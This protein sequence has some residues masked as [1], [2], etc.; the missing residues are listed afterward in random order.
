MLQVKKVPTMMNHDPERKTSTKPL[1]IRPYCQR[2]LGE[3]GPKIG[4]GFHVHGVSWSYGALTVSHRLVINNHSY[5]PFI[6]G[7]SAP[8]AQSSSVCIVGRG[9]PCGTRPFAKLEWL[10]FWSERVFKSMLGMKERKCCSMIYILIY[11]FKYI[12]YIYIPGTQMTF[13]F[14]GKGLV[15]GGWP[16]K[17][18]VIE[19][20]GIFNLFATYEFLPQK[21]EILQKVNCCETSSINNSLAWVVA[22]C[23]SMISFSTRLPETNIALENRPSQREN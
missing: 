19:V 12:R 10:F 13:V 21:W 22:P 16:S 14:V 2:G 4:P 7:H 9:L 18:E 5:L 8:G 3:G 1:N 15:L 20:P 11:M 6:I 17:I 23:Q